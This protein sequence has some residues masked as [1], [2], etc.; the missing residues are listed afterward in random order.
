MGVGLRAAGPASLSSFLQKR[1]N[2]KGNNKIT[3]PRLCVH[4]KH[5]AALTKAVGDL[6]IQ[7]LARL[8]VITSWK[9]YSFNP[10]M[11]SNS[12]CKGQHQCILN[13]CRDR[14]IFRKKKI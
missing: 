8:L 7:I 10:L 3:T 13:I 11:A 5:G 4:L 9:C 2:K 6:K 1:Q 12:P 14:C